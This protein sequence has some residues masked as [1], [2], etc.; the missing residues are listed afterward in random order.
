VQAHEWSVVERVEIDPEEFASAVVAVRN[1]YTHAGST[2]RNNQNRNP[3]SAKDLFFLSQQMSFLLRGALLLYLG[4]EEKQFSDVLV[5]QT[6][7]WK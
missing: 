1:F 7:R 4:I 5:H 2:M 6:T 3:V